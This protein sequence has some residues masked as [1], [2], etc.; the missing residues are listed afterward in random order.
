MRSK[1]NNEN[2]CREETT[3]IHERIFRSFEMTTHGFI[4]DQMDHL[5]IHYNRQLMDDSFIWQFV[6]SSYCLAHQH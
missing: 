5:P 2:T 6:S 3:E 1:S 4:V